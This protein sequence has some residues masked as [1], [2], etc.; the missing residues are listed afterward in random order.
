MILKK[1]VLPAWGNLKVKDITRRQIVTL[2]DQVKSRSQLAANNLHARLSMF[3]I[4]AVKRGIPGIDVSPFINIDVPA[5]RNK[6]KP[7]LDNEKVK[8]V[9]NKL[10]TLS[11]HE[12][13]KARLRLLLLTAQRRNELG[14]AEKSEFDLKTNEWT[15]PSTRT[16]NGITQVVPPSRQA[17]KIVMQLFDKNPNTKWLLSSNYGEDQ[18]F[19]ERALS[20]AVRNNEAQ[21]TT[22]DDKPIPHWSPHD[23]RRTATTTM[24]GQC[25]ID[26]FIV[27]IVLNHKEPKEFEITDISDRHEY[28]AEKRRALQK[29]ADKIDEILDEN[30]G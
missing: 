27:R 28:I 25:K 29:L 21:F 2:L 26:R 16:K 5:H 23:L 6:R 24:T 10:D 12:N 8:I 18:P 4:F 7:I 11:I 1:D 17:L 3:F 30:H 13:L 9:W 22:D 20:R 15:I 19:P 14:F